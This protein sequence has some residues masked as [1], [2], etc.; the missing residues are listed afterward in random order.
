MGIW[1]DVGVGVMRVGCC[2]RWGWEEGG[3][4]RV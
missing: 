2:W 4:L 1:I 3:I